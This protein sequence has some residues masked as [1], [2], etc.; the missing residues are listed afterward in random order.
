MTSITRVKCS[1]DCGQIGSNKHKYGSLEK[2]KDRMVSQ[3]KELS[4][5]HTGPYKE[6]NIFYH[7]TQ[8]CW[9]TKLKLMIS[10]VVS[11][12]GIFRLKR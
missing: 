3:F 4:Q 7:S 6:T 10:I 5:L 12:F 8:K 9:Q 2:T 1:D 11:K